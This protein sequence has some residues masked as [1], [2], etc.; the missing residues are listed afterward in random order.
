M[1][2]NSKELK[3][4]LTKNKKYLIISGVLLLVVAAVIICILCMNNNKNSL[5]NK[6]KDLGKDFYEN[7]YY[8]LVVKEHGVDQI[9]KYSNIGIKVSL[10][11]LGKFKKENEE[12]MN[13]F[14]NSKTKESCN[15]DET[16]VV[17]Y[18]TDPYGKTDYKLEVILDCGFEENNT[19]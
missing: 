18:P 19:K 14:V 2:K 17:I 8:D 16:K 9:S 13:D 15:K 11:T 5:E 10:N 3:S 4:F 12:K 7:F 1:K 6:L